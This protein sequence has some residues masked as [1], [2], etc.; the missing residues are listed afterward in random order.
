MVRV[1]NVRKRQYSRKAIRLN[2]YAGRTM[3]TIPQKR[4]DDLVAE[5]MRLKTQL[6]DLRK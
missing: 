1:T 3:I 6:I 2:L 5:V 4:Y